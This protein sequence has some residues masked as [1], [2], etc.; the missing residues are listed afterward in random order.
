ME[1]RE[2]KK[3]KEHMEQSLKHE[4][5]FELVNLQNRIEKAS[6]TLQHRNKQTK[7]LDFGCCDMEKHF[8]AQICGSHLQLKSYTETIWKGE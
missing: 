1:E 3:H 5:S 7:M 8:L 4:D 6:L 2:I